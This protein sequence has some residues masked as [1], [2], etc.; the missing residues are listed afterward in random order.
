MG[1]SRQD[2]ERFYAEE[3]TRKWL[4][5][6]A[7]GGLL[8][9]AVIVALS[10][11]ASREPESGVGASLPEKRKG[12]R[13]PDKET[14]GIPKEEEIGW[15][16]S[17]FSKPK[18][19]GPLSDIIY[20]GKEKEELRMAAVR[21]IGSI[22]T[23]NAFNILVDLLN[24]KNEKIRGA[25]VVHLGD[26]CDSRAITYLLPMLKDESKWIRGYAVSALGKLKA[27]NAFD[28]LVEMLK[29][30]NKFVRAEAAEALGV[31]G[32]R[33]AIQHLIKLMEDWDNKV[34]RSALRALHKIGS[35][36][37]VPVFIQALNSNNRSLKE[38]AA[39][40][41]CDLPDDSAVPALLS[42]L[43]Y[44]DRKVKYYCILALGIIGD[45][46]ASEPIK[47]LYWSEKDVVKA[48]AACVLMCNLDDKHAAEH[49]VSMLKSKQCNYGHYITK[50]L[51][52][53]GGS[54]SA[55]ILIRATD[56]ENCD[57]NRFGALGEIGDKKAVVL[58]IQA[59]KEGW[60]FYSSA[61]GSL[62]KIN[63]PEIK[64]PVR[65]IWIESNNDGIKLEAAFV[66]F[67]LYRDKDALNYIITVADDKMN[68]NR[69]RAIFCFAS[70]QD[71]R[72]V[73][74]LI[75]LLKDSGNLTKFGAAL[76]LNDMGPPRFGKSYEQWEKWLEENK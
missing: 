17:E 41:L 52:Y 23:D 49:L 2:S 40:A 55:E 33:R 1:F 53:M 10:L 35:K 56:K 54:K 59:L 67:K 74:Y 50:A 34:C 72:A 4:K 36:E 3:R 51:E 27:Y 58:L 70:T 76:S 42:N 8:V 62:I 66:L 26:R 31:L 20:N 11:V 19:L 22:G 64:E 32:E 12:G 38:I 28:Y 7:C 14:V 18:G 61:A 44:N 24:D 48:A 39:K 46:I 9:I 73:K 47:S 30:E 43:T 21:A 15:K 68:P 71:R 75:E 45:R 60:E 5:G 37:A 69:V 29:D 25:A 13:P 57:G 63:V 6:C 65:K 16:L